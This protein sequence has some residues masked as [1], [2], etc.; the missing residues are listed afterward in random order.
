MDY[1]N[2]YETL[3]KEHKD[4]ALKAYHAGNSI[5]KRKEL[6]KDMELYLNLLTLFTDHLKSRIEGSIERTKK[7][8]AR[9]E[10]ASEAAES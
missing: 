7:Q 2:C 9:I 3:I 1:I 8:I 5:D 6:V 10:H 4:I